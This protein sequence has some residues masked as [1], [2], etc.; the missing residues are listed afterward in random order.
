MG[1][2]TCILPA[3]LQPYASAEVDAF[4]PDFRAPRAQYGGINLEKEVGGGF[5]G[6]LSYLFY[7]AWI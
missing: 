4:A 6:T 5:K 7:T 3:A 1:P 2:V